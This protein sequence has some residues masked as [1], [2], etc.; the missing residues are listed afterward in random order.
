M[1][2]YDVIVV[3]ARAAGASTALQ[4]AR[5]GH[6]VLVL[7]RAP[8]GSDTLSTHALMRTG[9]LLLDR[10]GLLDRVTAAGTPP[11]HRVT[12]RYGDE[13][14]PID[15]DQPLYAPRRTVLDPILGDAAAEAGADVRYG[16]RVDGLLRDGTGR[17]TGIRASSPDGPLEAV[18]TVTVGADGLRSL[19]A[20]EVAAPV[21]RSGTASGAFVY[22]YWNGIET[23]GIEY[24]FGDGISAGFIPTNHGQTCIYV[25][26]SS[27]RFLTELRFDLDGAFDRVIAEAPARVRDLVAPGTRA[28]RL[29]GFPGVPGRFHRPFG[30]GWALVG[31]AGYFKDPQTAH[32][33][34]DALRDGELLARAIDEGLTGR[35]DLGEALAGYERTRDDLSV[36]LFAAA[37]GIAG[38]GWSLDELPPLHIAMSKAMQRETAHMDALTAPL[39]P[40]ATAAA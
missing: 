29:R 17:V 40:A 37:E 10:W 39:A 6:R 4:L 13:P 28:S 20:R 14:V 38:H 12:F 9:V 34:T 21:T 22:G 31:D 27:Q 26:T 8:R 35:R 36:P 7:E 24:L 25:S 15:L 3:G 32:G 19:V 5:R 1:P 11:V 2:A 18:A 30:P 16:V 23:D 33:I